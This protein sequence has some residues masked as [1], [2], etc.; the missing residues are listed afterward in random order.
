[1]DVAV[2]PDVVAADVRSDVPPAVDP[3]SQIA[4]PRSALVALHFEP[5]YGMGATDLATL[6]RRRTDQ[7][8]RGTL[9]RGVQFPL[10]ATVA[11]PLVDEV[12]GIQGLRAQTVVRWLDP[13]TR[14]VSPDAPRFGANT[15]YVAWF[16]DGWNT[17]PADPP[18]F[19]GS[20]DRGWIWTNHEY[21]SNN[22]PTTT[23]AP[24]GQHLQFAQYLRAAGVLNRDVTDPTW[25]QSEVDTYI[26]AWKRQVGGSWFRVV[27]DPATGNLQVDRDAY[28]LRYDATAATLSR[29]QGRA[30]GTRR[31]NDDRG[32]MLPEGVVAGTSS[33]CSGGVS[34]WGTVFTGEENTQGAWGDPEPAWNSSNLFVAGQGFDPGA[35][36][37]PNITPGTASDFGRISVAAERHAPDL[38]GYLVEVDVGRAPDDYYGRNAPGQ[39]HRKLGHFGRARWENATFAVD[40]DWRLVAGRRVTVYYGDDRTSGRVY[41]WVS[42]MPYAAGMTRA[43][44]RALLDDGTLYV[45]HFAGLDNTTGITLAATRMPPT[46]TAPGMGRWIEL[47]TTSADVAPNAAALGAATRTVGE[48]LRDARWNSMGAFATNDAVYAATFSASNKVGVMELNRPE[49]LE[50]NP[51]DLSG[52]PRVYVAFTN[53]TRPTALDDRGV[54]RTATGTARADRAGSIFAL[55]EATPAEP[56]TSMTFRYFMAWQGAIGTGVFDA[57]SPDNILIDP[58]G[59][60]WFGTDGNFGLNGHPDGVYYLDLDPMHRAGTMGVTTPSYGLAFR[61]VTVPSDAEATGPAFSS[62]TRTLFISVQHPGE[63]TFSTFATP[64]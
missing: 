55:E 15:D 53:D 30:L 5:V 39:G 21:I 27:R 35:S 16:G 28:N 33:N 31:D 51:R 13:L 64:R 26:R 25:T 59:G 36:V 37:T 20:G 11:T 14:D 29:L 44:V 38:H 62:D 3:A 50:Y 32:S 10:P 4:G 57:G 9:P 63:D 12:R 42:R 58:Q 2:A 22:A 60:V 34:P 17:N 52:R 23:T 18:Q 41:K 6:A 45:A 19:R 24:T 56:D 54:L 1:M 46:E 40:R 8:A 43:Q 48:A 61:V 49:D 47:S 7:Y